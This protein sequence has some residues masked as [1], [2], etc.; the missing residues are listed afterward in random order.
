MSQQSLFDAPAAEIPVGTVTRAHV[1]NLA[2][3]DVISGN[4]SGGG[5]SWAMQC[6]LMDAAR[7][8]GVENRVYT[9]HATLGPLEWP[10]VE[11]GGQRFPSAAEL[12][13]QQSAASGVPAER[14]LERRKLT[15]DTE[16]APH[17]L[18]TYI[19]EY[20]RFPRIGMRFC[21]KAHKES[22]EETAFTP[23]LNE[24]K[25]PLGL[26]RTPTAIKLT[27]PVRRLKVLGLLGEESRDR[28]A[29]PAYRHVAGNGVRHV[30]EWCPAKEWTKAQVRDFHATSGMP[31]HW[32][33]D[34]HPGAGD[35]GGTSRCSCSLC[36]LSSKRDLLLGV[37]RRPRLAALIAHVEHVRGDTFRPDWSM[38]DLI[39]WSQLPGAPSPGVVIADETPAFD[40]LEESVRAALRKPPRKEPDLSRGGRAALPLLR[41]TCTT[42][43]S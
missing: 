42:A 27:R 14:H 28:A 39:A 30:D 19:A 18:L 36:F 1:P 3:Y 35:W 29:R 22:L 13:A 17:D 16:P 11:Y 32:T 12:A 2:D 37:L 34:S 33:Y 41:D 10:E 21:T 7:E 24:L 43:C 25:V 23:V 31:H 5:D 40:A 9:F 26:A 8:A 6:L 4:L 20:G 15:Q 38:H